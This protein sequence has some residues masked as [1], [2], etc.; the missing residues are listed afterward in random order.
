M[1]SVVPLP[2]GLVT[3][4]VPPSAAIRSLRPTSPDPRAGSAPPTPSSRIASRRIMLRHAGEPV[5]DLRQL[6]A[7]LA[8]LGRY[9]RLHHPQV[10]AQR[11][12]LLLDAFV[13]ITLDPPPRLI[14]GGDDPRPG[15]GQGGQ[16]LH[17]RDRRGHELGEA[18][19]TRLGVPGERRAPRLRMEKHN[20]PQ[21]PLDQDRAGDRGA[22]PELVPDERRDEPGNALIVVYPD[23]GPG[24]EDGRGQIASFERPWP[25]NQ[26][27]LLTLGSPGGQD[28]HR[29]IALVA[30][31]PGQ[32]RAEQPPG[33]PGDRREHLVRRHL[34]RHQHRHPPQ[35]RLL[36]GQHTQIVHA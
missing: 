23:R 1:S 26:G 12:Q 17:V 11:H 5:G 27:M 25:R 10:Q 36:L 29:R 13:Q 24:P 7:Q 22:N 19:E 3:S 14:G 30:A 2:T 6:A 15:D 33:L 9:R 4:S 34:A 20:A 35:R 32:V 28:S 18:G 8:E 21:P 31:H 16:A